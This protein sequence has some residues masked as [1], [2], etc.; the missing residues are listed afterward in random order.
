MLVLSRKIGDQLILKIGHE[1]VVVQVCKISGN[2]VKIGID[3][4]GQVDVGRGELPALS[5]VDQSDGSRGAA[6]Q[7]QLPRI[8]FLPVLD[9]PRVQR[10]R[11]REAIGHC[12]R[13]GRSANLGHD[14]RLV[15][16]GWPVLVLPNCPSP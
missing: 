3:A 1:T 10:T 12:C 9:H 2:R 15:V 4:S 6:V 13:E 8:P 7:L 5:A 11:A 16:D 14:R